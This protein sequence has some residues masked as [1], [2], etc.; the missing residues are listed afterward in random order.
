MITKQLLDNYFKRQCTAEEQVEVEG[1]L[2]SDDHTLLDEFLSNKWADAAAAPSD[3]V[4]PP[5]IIL[6]ARAKV[7]KLPVKWTR[8]AAVFTGLLTLSA[9]AVYMF[10]TI[11]KTSAVSRIAKQQWRELD[12]RGTAIRS[13]V[14]GDGTKIWLNKN[15]VLRYPDNYNKDTRDV[16]LMGEAYFEVAPD[17]TKPFRV[18]TANVITTA[19]G[20]AF[21]ISAFTMRDTA[22]RVSLLEGK[23]AVAT[24]GSTGNV[25]ARILTPGM[26]VDFEDNILMDPE[27]DS[28]VS[29]VTG[30]I[31]DKVY[32]NNTTLKEVCRRLSYQYSENIV[33]TGD[34]GEQRISG[35]F[36]TSDDL[37]T[38]VAAITYV[39]KLKVSYS[40]EGCR[41]SK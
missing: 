4:I 20:T 24:D 33:T 35:V 8:Y 17:Q 36:N 16:A 25:S 15:A 32:F 10:S 2:N 19:L 31:K 38:I 9:A 18:H 28:T 29:N 30:W 22:I 39:H 26:T 23:V 7:R 34:A 1:Y 3:F 11:G 14:M 40:R 21:N 37:K 27:T 41:I 5:P 12:N 13:V 6:P